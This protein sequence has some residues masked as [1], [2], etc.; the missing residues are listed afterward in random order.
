M[1]RSPR[2][3]TLY[4]LSVVFAAA[5]I[6]FA[7]IRATNSHHDLRMLWMAF[8]ALGVVM[9]VMDLGRARR[10]TPRGVLG[11]AV[12]ALVAATV[13]AAWLAY[14]LGATAAAGIWP[15]AFVLSVCWA[16]S[17]ALDALSRP[18]LE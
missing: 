2:Q 10:R 9:L 6:V 8:A 1:T 17:R 12:V 5:P 7:L 18:P 15:V 3:Q 16:G 14:R 4:T 11:L 13:V